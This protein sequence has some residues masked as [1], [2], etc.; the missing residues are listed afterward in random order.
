[1]VIAIIL[2]GCI[3]RDIYYRDVALFGTQAVVDRVI[4]VLA[5]TLGVARAELGVV[6]R[7]STLVTWSGARD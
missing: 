7:V 4:E 1:M 5:A 6:R 3:F 2:T